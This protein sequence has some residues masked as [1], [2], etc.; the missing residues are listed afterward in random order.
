MQVTRYVVVLP[1]VLT[2]QTSGLAPIRHRHQEYRQCRELQYKLVEITIVTRSKARGE[3]GGR[4][5]GKGVMKR[6]EGEV[7]GSVN[8]GGEGGGR[9]RGRA[10]E[11]RRGVG[12][13]VGEGG[14]DGRER[15][16]RERQRHDGT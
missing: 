14:G 10:E 16:E 7:W 12:E 6:E 4:G 13:G 2:V 8:G 1:H 11:W 9:G 5:G 15:W 3:E